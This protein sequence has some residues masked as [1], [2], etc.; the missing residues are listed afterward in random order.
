MFTSMMALVLAFQ[1]SASGAEVKWTQDYKQ[2][3]QQSLAQNKPIAVVLAAGEKGYT[4][5][6]LSKEALDQLS[7]NYICVYVD[8]T[9]PA[10]KDLVAAFEMP[11]GK[12]IVLSD[13]TGVYENYRQ[14]GMLSSAD[15]TAKL[16]QY[17]ATTSTSFYRAPD[18]SMQPVYTQPYAQPGYGVV[19]PAVNYCPT[20]GGGGR[21]R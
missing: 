16:R 1:V 12:G 7:A 4:Q 2:A 9:N 15:M 5:L 14:E 13:R 8:T 18:G 10:N 21:Y 17:G 3:R 19:Q 11:G 6:G 20:C